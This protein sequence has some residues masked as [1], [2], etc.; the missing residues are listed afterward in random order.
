MPW[1]WI[2][3]LKGRQWPE[4]G[5]QQFL[6]VHSKKL[7]RR[8]HFLKEVLRLDNTFSSGV[9]DISVI[10]EYIWGFV[11]LKKY[12]IPTH[13]PVDDDGTSGHTVSNSVFDWVLGNLSPLYLLKNLVQRIKL[14]AFRGSALSF[15]I[16]VISFFTFQVEPSP[17]QGV[18]THFIIGTFSAVKDK[19]QALRQGFDTIFRCLSV[20][21]I[22][23]LTC[24]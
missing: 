11:V 15:F 23:S 5:C 8:W 4:S 1:L 18:C 14:M 13:R 17:P 24:T 22:T 6:D 21:G 20:K 3:N 10:L 19:P 12:F 2:L 16:Q 7:L 9:W